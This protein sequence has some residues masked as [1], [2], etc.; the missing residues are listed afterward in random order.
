MID[1]Q[2]IDEIN[3]LPWVH[4]I[5][6]GNG[7]VTPGKWPINRLI[8]QAFDQIDFQGKRVLD[9]GCWDGLWS[10]E[11]EKRGAAEV[12]A[13]DDLSQRDYHSTRTFALAKEV[14]RSRVRYFPEMPI[15]RV[16]G[17]GVKFD[18]VLFLGV[19]YHLRDPLRALAILRSVL[20]DGG[21]IVVEGAVRYNR[22]ASFAD[23]LYHEVRNRDS[24]NW[25]IP[26]VK[27]LEEW[28]ESS[29]F[30]KQFTCLYTS[31]GRMAT[32]SSRPV[33]LAR[34]ALGMVIPRLKFGRAVVVAQA[35]SGKDPLWAYPDPLFAGIDGNGYS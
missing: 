2:L 30:R 13:T 28:I 6:L 12:Y 15:E 32:R 35:F 23:F 27:C 17:L 10:F 21:L 16:P 25:W 34:R 7:I 14:L 20:N 33:Y 31:G 3:A 4:S 29:F 9:I 24:S 11:A 19:Y 1:T 18:I 26:T 8:L 5:D 22:R